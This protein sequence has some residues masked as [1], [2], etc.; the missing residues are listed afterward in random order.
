MSYLVNRNEY[1]VENFEDDQ[2]LLNELEEAGE[3]TELCLDII[4]N[5]LLNSKSERNSKDT[6]LNWDPNIFNNDNPSL[7]YLPLFNGSIEHAKSY[8][9]SQ[10]YLSQIQ[11]QQCYI[12]DD[13]YMNEQNPIYENQTVFTDFTTKTN[14]KLEIQNIF[15]KVEKSY[16]GDSDHMFYLNQTQNIFTKSPNINQDVSSVSVPSSTNTSIS[17]TSIN[18]YKSINILPP[19]N[20]DPNRHLISSSELN[21]K[22]DLQLPREPRTK[23]LLR[24]AML[25]QEYMNSGFGVIY[26]IYILFCKAK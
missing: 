1:D 13:I 12:Y 14:N 16:S 11:P 19:L 20:T 5:A 9:K 22:Y 21:K 17:E 2:E 8:S 26:Y 10:S 23:F 7:N 15:N 25:W 6:F 18:N 24:S 3:N 4:Q